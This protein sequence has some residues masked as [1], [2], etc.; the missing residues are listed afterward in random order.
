MGFLSYHRQFIKGF[1]ARVET[2]AEMLRKNQK[3][4][5]NK[6]RLEAFEDLKNALMTAPVLGVYRQE[7]NILIDVDTSGTSCGASKS[8][9]A[10][11]VCWSTPADAC[12]DRSE[13]SV[14]F[15]ARPWD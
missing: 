13:T 1:A 11:S 14:L 8:K 3:I 15:A 9:T 12:H 4:Q 2:L 5:P 10:P 6:R 7:G